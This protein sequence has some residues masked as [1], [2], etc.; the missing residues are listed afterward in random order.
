MQI[1]KTTKSLEKL[2]KT[3][4]TSHREYNKSFKETQN[5]F[6]MNIN[7]NAEKLEQ[8]IEVSD[9]N[10]MY[11]IMRLIGIKDFKEKM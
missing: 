9:A 5:S 11:E 2:K 1:L 3:I 10:L 8:E 4:G 6:Q 7:F